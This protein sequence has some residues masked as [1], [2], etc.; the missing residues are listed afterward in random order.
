M[1]QG[2]LNMDARTQQIL[3]R[4]DELARISENPHQLTR[5]FASPAMRQAN[6]LVAEWMRAAGL[7]T[8]VD[9]MGNLIG[10]LAGTQPKSKVFLLGS[11]LD[12][13]R[14]AGK[15]DGPLG[16]ILAIACVE[17]LQRDKI[18]LPFDIGVLG[19]AD[20]EG[21]RYQTTYLGSRAVTGTFDT[22]DLERR[23]AGGISLR[24]ALRAF[25]GNPDQLSTARW[26]AKNILGYLEAHIEQGPVLEKNNL[27]V[28]VVTSISGQSRLQVRFVGHAGHA[29]TTPMNLRTDALCTAA[30]FI[31]TVEKHARKT[32]G[33]VATVGQIQ[34][35]PGTSNVIPG[36]ATLTLDVRHQKNFARRSAVTALHKTAVQIS[37]RRHTKL[38]WQLV[39][40]TASVHCSQPLSQTLA[41]AVKRHQP[42]CLALPGGAGH[43]AAVMAGIAPAAML[44]IRCKKGLSHNPAE[45]VKTGDVTVAL[46]VMVDFIRQMA[47]QHE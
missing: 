37:R 19:F 28:A 20:E 45:A 46:K 16:V 27:P 22:R 18:P 7:Q 4:I 30:E 41:T 35:E 21:V 36:A 47:K 2:Q 25:G 17:E 38:E 11:H 12:T 14:N 33:L 8:C 29:G 42:R 26:S 43:D 10:R 6:D 44:F 31:L 32:T 9:A 24:D 40:Q 5:T 34:A 39:Q 15:Y 3:Q 1:T 13:V 23:D